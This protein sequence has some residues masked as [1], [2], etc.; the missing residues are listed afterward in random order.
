MYVL[1]SCQD[2]AVN[3]CLSYI[4][5]PQN[6]PV[7]CVLPT[8]AGKSLV[9]NE[10][11]RR[12]GD[13]ALVLQPSIEL[14]KQNYSKAEELGCIGM[15]M[16]SAGGGSKEFGYLTY[17]TLGSIKSLAAMFKALGVTTVL[18]DECHTGV[19]PA[20]GSMF[21]K[22]IRA[23][24]PKKVIGF[25]ATPYRLQSTLQGS[26]LVMLHRVFPTYFR[27]IIHV[28]QIKEMLD[29]GWWTPINYEY[30]EFDE[31]HLTL[32][33]SGTDFTEESIKKAIEVQ[34]INNNIFMRIHN[35]YEQGYS[36]ILVFTDSV[37]TA[38]RF[39][40]YIP[41]SAYLS[42]DTNKKDRFQIVEDFK[43]GKIKTLFNYNILA[44]GF[45]Y[46]ELECVIMGRPT[47]SLAVY[48]Q[49]V[50]RGARISKGKSE[51]LF[52]D[53][54]GNVERFGRVEQQEIIN[55]EGHGWGVFCKN[56]LV[57]DVFLD[58]GYTVTKEEISEGFNTDEIETEEIWFGKHKGK[59][60]QQLVRQ[61]PGYVKFMFNTFDF[62]TPKM[63]TLKRDLEKLMKSTVIK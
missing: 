25:T 33:S 6:Y 20:N 57:T 27:Q 59:T 52:V 63:Q 53:Y 15:T 60:P 43:S 12:S 51:Y 47:N 37:D 19:S 30:Y 61:Y 55:Y 26:K 28:T 62:G 16:Y 49:I 4:R 31:S 3:N 38:K 54:G 11:A 45:D 5:S 7:V 34:G 22:F 2:S 17:A 39:A 44:T 46:P 29:N 48:Y 1:R 40:E 10:V 24:N 42:A 8:A 41:N 9:I 21:I 36:R 56:E 35:L 50:G 14:L 32:N 18:I 23:L 58:G 13:K